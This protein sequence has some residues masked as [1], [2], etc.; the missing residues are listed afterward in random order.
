V[1]P[2]KGAIGRI[3][4]RAFGCNPIDGVGPIE[5]DD[6]NI[7]LL[8]CAHAQKHRPD[9]RII[10]G[11]DILEIDK[12]PLDA[13]EHGGRRFAMLAVEAVNRNPQSRVFVSLPFHHVVL[14][15]TEVTMLRPEKRMKAKKAAV[16]ALENMR[17]VLKGAR[18]GGGMKQRTQPHVPQLLRPKL[19]EMI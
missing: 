2:H 5:D 17:R 3:Q 19:F 10:T 9:K 15:L 8:T 14:G 12:K 11:A 4:Q 16:I 7:T 6:V 1:E 13:F 18:D